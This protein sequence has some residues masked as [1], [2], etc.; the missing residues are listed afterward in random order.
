MYKFIALISVVLYNGNNINVKNITTILSKEG[1][2][3]KLSV[4]S[5]IDDL[6]LQAAEIKILQDSITE[7]FNCFCQVVKTSGAETVIIFSAINSLN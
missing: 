3:Y 1:L 6:Y 4:N 5:E 7:M 2:A